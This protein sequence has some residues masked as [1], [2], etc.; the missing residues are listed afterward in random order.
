MLIFQFGQLQKFKR[1]PIGKSQNFQYG[2]FQKYSI[3]NTKNFE[4]GK[5]QKLTIWKI[6]KKSQF[7]KTSKFPI[8]KS[9]IIFNLENL[10]N[11]KNCELRKF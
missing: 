9:L 2:K 1:F 7:V 8:G 4:L 10:K 6:R 3:G 11:F 5:L